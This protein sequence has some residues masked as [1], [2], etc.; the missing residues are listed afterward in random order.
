MAFGTI[1][2]CLLLFAQLKVHQRPLH[3]IITTYLTMPLEPY[4]YCFPRLVSTRITP[5]A[6]T[7]YE[8]YCYDAQRDNQQHGA[9]YRTYLLDQFHA[10]A[11]IQPTSIGRC[12]F[13]NSGQKEAA[14]HLEVGAPQYRQYS[15]FEPFLKAHWETIRLYHSGIYML[16]A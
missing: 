1:S 5:P 15:A 3:Q 11:L 7:I 8:I 4:S 14:H 12:S 13:L 6:D 9:C 16:S 2:D 10:D